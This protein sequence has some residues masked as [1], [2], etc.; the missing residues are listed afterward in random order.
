MPAWGRAQGQHLWRVLSSNPRAVFISPGTCSDDTP[1]SRRFLSTYTSS[2]QAENRSRF[3]CGNRRSHDTE[4]V[5]VC[6]CVCFVC[7][8]CTV[9]WCVC[10]CICVNKSIFAS[11]RRIS[12]HQTP[13]LK[14][15]TD[16]WG[17]KKSPNSRAKTKRNFKSSDNLELS[18]HTPL[19][20][21]SCKRIHF[22]EGDPPLNSD[23]LDVDRGVKVRGERYHLAIVR[24]NNTYIYT[25]K[26][27]LFKTYAKSIA[28]LPSA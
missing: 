21:V 16:W 17:E 7:V 12:V 8:Y 14:N 9:L 3:I 4:R 10:V 15:A 24:G 23:G 27:S 6:V 2:R 25:Y 26:L 20:R 1:S 28:M 13:S 22:A 5:C 11:H 18:A 19:M